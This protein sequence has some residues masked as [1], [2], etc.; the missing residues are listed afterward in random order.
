MYLNVSFQTLNLNDTTRKR[1][2]GIEMRDSVI[3]SLIRAKQHHLFRYLVD[4]DHILNFARKLCFQGANKRRDESS[5][6]FYKT[7]CCTGST[8]LKA[9]Y[10]IGKG[11]VALT[12]GGLLRRTESGGKLTLQ[13]TRRV[14]TLQK[15]RVHSVEQT[16]RGRGVSFVH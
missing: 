14:L 16:A 6:A 9:I 13:K 3:I 15:V 7:R 1:Y 12:A 5:Y 11:C 8:S 4:W 2:M 10:C